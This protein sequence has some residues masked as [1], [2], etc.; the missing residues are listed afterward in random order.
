MSGS[1][2]VVLTPEVKTCDSW[3]S[4]TKLGA[5]MAKIGSSTTGLAKIGSSTTGLSTTVIVILS[6]FNADLALLRVLKD[7]SVRM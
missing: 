2:K 4:L 1:T 6:V 7:S 3:K 5:I